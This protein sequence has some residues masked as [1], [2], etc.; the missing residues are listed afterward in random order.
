M[1]EQLG[2]RLWYWK[3]FARM[4]QRKCLTT[5]FEGYESVYKSGPKGL[6]SLAKTTTV[7]TEQMTINWVWTSTGES[8][9]SFSPSEDQAFL[10][11]Q[12][13]HRQL[14]KGMTSGK[15]AMLWWHTW[16]WIWWKTGLF[17]FFSPGEQE[18]CWLDLVGITIV[19]FVMPGQHGFMENAASQIDEFLFVRLEN[20]LIKVAVL[21]TGLRVTDCRIVSYNND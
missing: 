7:T 3:R 15:L 6:D 18:G 5:I 8:L 20:W 13:R 4:K 12:W 2:T 1:T 17:Q 19:C 11:E 21:S 16:Y 9:G 14:V 10:L